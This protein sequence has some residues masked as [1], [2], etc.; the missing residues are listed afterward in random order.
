MFD[1]AS[2]PPAQ[3]LTSPF[4]GQAFELQEM[5]PEGT[6]SLEVGFASGEVFISLVQA[7]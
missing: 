1:T 4:T 3:S 2:P 7:A 6:G 5:G